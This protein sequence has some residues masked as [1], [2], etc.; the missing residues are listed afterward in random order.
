MVINDAFIKIKMQECLKDA[1]IPLVTDENYIK[2][3]IHHYLVT[4]N[5]F[6]DEISKFMEMSFNQA[7]DFISEQDEK[8]ES[9]SRINFLNQKII[10]KF[11]NELAKMNKKISQFKAKKSKKEDDLEKFEND[12]ESGK[13]E[14]KNIER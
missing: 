8:K 3:F 1:K 12:L 5:S 14:E 2:R 11:G 9:T 4:E 13:V 7:R 6:D 10:P